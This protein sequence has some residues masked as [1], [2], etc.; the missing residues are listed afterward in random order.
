MGCPIQVV[1]PLVP[2]IAFMGMS[3]TNHSM[4]LL[5][6]LES[7]LLMSVA[8]PNNSMSDAVKLGSLSGR[9]QVSDVVNLEDTADWFRFEVAGRGKFSARVR[10]SVP[11]GVSL[12]F[13]EDKNGDLQPDEGE[14]I[15]TLG[16]LGEGGWRATASLQVQP[17]KVYYVAVRHA[18]SG[19]GNT[20]DRNYDLQLTADTAGNTLATAHD[21]ATLTEARTF[22]EFVGNDPGTSHH[23]PADVYAI[24]LHGTTNSILYAQLETEDGSAFEGTGPKLRYVWD[25]NNNGFLDASDMVIDARSADSRYLS[26]GFA[27]VGT[28][29]IVVESD[30]NVGAQRYKLTLNINNA[31]NSRDGATDLGTLLGKRQIQDSVWTVQGQWSDNDFYRFTLPVAAQVKVRPNRPPGLPSAVKWTLTDAAENTLLDL[32]GVGGSAELPAGTYFL[33]ISKAASATPENY[34]L[35]IAAD[36]AGDYGT[37]ARDLGTPANVVRVNEYIDEMDDTDFTDDPRDHYRFRV[38]GTVA[39]PVLAQLSSPGIDTNLVL[40]RESPGAPGMQLITE[41]NKRGVSDAISAN[42]APGT[43]QLVVTSASGRG[44]YSLTLW[45]GDADDTIREVNLRPSNRGAL[46]RPINGTLESSTDVDLFSFRAR[47]DQHVFFDVDSRLGSNFDSYLR[48]F[49]SS[50]REL[51]SNDDG[52]FPGERPSKFSVLSHRFAQSGTYYIGISASPNRRY[53]ATSGNGDVVGRSFGAYRVAMNNIL[54]GTASISGTVFNDRNGNGKRDTGEAGLA[55]R[56][57]FV[58]RNGNGACDDDEFGALTDANGNFRIDSLPQGD[59]ILRL[60]ANTGW[61][62]TTPGSG[63]LLVLTSADR[64]TVGHLFGLRKI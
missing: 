17:G 3:H 20:L 24:D 30:P 40:L 8:E 45:P 13:L 10:N 60:V 5:E 43:Y 14:I 53:S 55:G 11:T 64:V 49:D 39:I 33:S 44:N 28:R 42:L 9:V 15:G 12:Q 1:A 52:A 25:A 37:V 34:T 29:F 26:V 58:D 27:D 2:T 19:N 6:S 23:D 41:S 32:E 61:R 38:G 48:L 35:V 56:T 47:A 31:G 57:V 18:D 21:L 4:S 46:G 54:T 62:Q 50:G 59:E 7:R 16:E 63:G 36:S 51:A 22:I